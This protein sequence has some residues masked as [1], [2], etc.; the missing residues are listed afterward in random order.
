MASLSFLDIFLTV[1]DFT[2]KDPFLYRTPS[3]FGAIF[4][5]E[6]IRYYIVGG[7]A[8]IHHQMVRNTMDIDVTVHENDFEKATKVRFK[9]HLLIWFD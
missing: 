5:E 2:S 4:K 8:L 1:M 3:K 9:Y 6:Q 7:Y